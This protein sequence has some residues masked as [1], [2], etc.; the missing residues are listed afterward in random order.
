MVVYARLEPKE[1]LVIKKAVLEALAASVKAQSAAS[2]FSKLRASKKA[3]ISE[4]TTAVQTMAQE[5]DKIKK[6]LP[7]ELVQIKETEH[8][9]PA[10]LARKKTKYEL[11]LE[12]LKE[13]IASLG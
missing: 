9:K 1:E 11:E 6:E 5:L 4:L 7:A 8:V 10:K 3:A 2:E 12:A 13:K